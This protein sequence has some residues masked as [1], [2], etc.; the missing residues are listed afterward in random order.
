[1]T[2]IR[3][4]SFDIAG[5]TGAELEIDDGVNPPETYVYDTELGNDADA[6]WGVAVD[7][8]RWANDAGR[9]W[10]GS[11][12]F[13]S[14][15]TDEAIFHGIILTAS[16]S[17]TWTPNTTMK[18]QFAFLPGSTV[19]VSLSSR[20]GLPGTVRARFELINFARH[21]DAKGLA[22]SEGSWIDDS[23]KFA[24]RLPGLT[25]V[26]DEPLLL[27]FR[28]AQEAATSPRQAYVNHLAVGGWRRLH[29]GQ[30]GV[31]REAFQLYRSTLRAVG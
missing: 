29:I 31:Q 14:D 21:L 17:V 15:V 28:V 22:A 27:A 7:I 20:S 12:T 5:W 3:G 1:M 23:P 2:A 16:S 10:F 26:L 11:I 13:T 30:I 8:V 19:G 9:A 6:H 18:D 4:I 24:F 25:V